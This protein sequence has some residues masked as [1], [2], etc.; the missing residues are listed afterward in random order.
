[1]LQV[2]NT[3]TIAYPLY[4]VTKAWVE[5]TTM[6]LRVLGPLDIHYAGTTAWG[7]AGASSITGSI[8]RGNTNLW[9]STTSSFSTSLAAKR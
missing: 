8:D 5:G 4:D 9:S 2:T 6:V 1:M 7:T 3:S